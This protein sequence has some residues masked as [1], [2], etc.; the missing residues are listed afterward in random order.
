MPCIAEIMKWG[1]K[2]KSSIEARPTVH[3]AWGCWAFLKM[4]IVFTLSSGMD[5]D[6]LPALRRRGRGCCR[7]RVAWRVRPVCYSGCSEGGCAWDRTR[8]PVARGARA[9]SSRSR[10]RGVEFVEAGF[11]PGVVY[12]R[13][14][15]RRSGRM[16]LAVGWW[17]SP[18]PDGNA[19]PFYVDIASP[20]VFAI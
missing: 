18:C 8:I 17:H 2:K 10:R 14:S 7:K 20:S 5:A 6:G 16:V 9:G 13:T 12:R 11:Y 4:S 19:S 3:T 15:W 1:E